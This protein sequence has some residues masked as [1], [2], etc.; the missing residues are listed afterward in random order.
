MR[1]DQTIARTE[2]RSTVTQKIGEIATIV[3]S[4]PDIWIRGLDGEDLNAEERVVFYS[5]VEVVESYFFDMF[6]R[7]KNLEIGSFEPLARDFAFAVYMYPG[8]KQAY[9]SEY[10][11]DQIRNQAYGEDESRTD[12]FRNLV[13]QYLDELETSA[14]P[15]P[16]EKRYVFW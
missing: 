9:F 1:Q 4:N 11:S 10:E 14:P 13:M 6:L 12:D 15:V 2:T 3:E 7:F 16:G 8:L 5:M